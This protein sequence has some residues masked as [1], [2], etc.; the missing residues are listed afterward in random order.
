MSTHSFPLF[1][2]SRVVEGWSLFRL[3]GEI[4]SEQ[5]PSPSLVSKIFHLCNF[6]FRYKQNANVT[7]CITGFWIRIS[8]TLINDEWLCYM[9]N[10][11][12]NLLHIK[13]GEWF[14]VY[15]IECLFETAHRWYLFTCISPSEF[16]A[17]QPPFKLQPPN[18]P[19]VIHKPR[20]GS[21]LRC[22]KKAFR[23]FLET[24][25][26]HLLMCPEGS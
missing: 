5:V 18:R 14:K 4:Q 21:P 2:F 9:E 1:D 24:P 13:F 23:T 12:C 17:I 8:H 10:M 16:T 26:V 3:L 7:K 20:L 22:Q 25:A 11:I 6:I 15:L 19:S